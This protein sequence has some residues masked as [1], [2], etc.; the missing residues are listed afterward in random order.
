VFHFDEVHITRRPPAAAPFALALPVP[1]AVALPDGRQLVASAARGP[2]TGDASA[3]VVAVPEGP[4]EV[5]TRRPGDRVHA[6]GRDLSL[7]RFLMD[8]RVP[9]QERA[10]LPL[11]AAGHRVLWVSGQRIDGPVTAERRFVRLELH[12]GGRH[13]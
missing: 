8:R 3:A 12:P 1:G 6:S 5:R 9:A 10:S 11:L 4:L 7:K 13:H 2:A